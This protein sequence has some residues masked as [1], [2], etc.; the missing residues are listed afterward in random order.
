MKKKELK[1]I[2]KSYLKKNLKISI[3]NIILKDKL[4]QTEVDY[5]I[6]KQ[7]LHLEKSKEIN[8]YSIAN[9][10]LKN[11]TIELKREIEKLYKDLEF[12]FI[13]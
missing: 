3:K 12:K 1:K 4:R 5:I 6:E 11:E 8:K 9:T 7:A 13:Q 2:I 10:E